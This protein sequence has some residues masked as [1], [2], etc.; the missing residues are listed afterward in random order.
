MPRQPSGRPTIFE[1]KDGLYHC[2][3]AIGT[4]TDGTP[5]RRHI[6]RKTAAAVA[7]AIEETLKRMRQ[8]SGNLAKIE[9][10]EQWLAHWVHVILVSKRDSGTMAWNSWEDYE[11][12]SRVHLV[13][14]LGR[15]RITGTKRRMEPEYPEALYAQLRQHDL[16]PSYVKRIH[17]V[18]CIAYKAAFKRGRADRNVMELV[19]A[20]EFR[21]KKIPALPQ[22]DAA[23]VLAEA[24]R[25]EHAA[26]WGLGIVAGPR[27]GEV[28]GIRWPRVDLDPE[29]PAVAHVMMATQIQRRKWRHG[30]ADPV[31][32]VASRDLC[33]TKRCE[34]PFGHGCAGAC[35][36]KLA[37]YC[38]SRVREGDCYRH[39]TKQGEPKPC[40]P[41]CPPN[42]AGHAST[43][44]QR[45]GGGLVETALKT[46][47]SEA[48]MVLGSV[49]TELLRRHREQQIQAGTFD[50][51]GFVFP[52][53]RKGAPLDPRQDYANWCNLLERAGVQ[54]YRLHSARHTAGTFASATGADLPMIRDMLR[55]ADTAVAA[56]Y[57]DNALD[58][59]RDAV[60]RVAAALFDG[61]LSMILGA[62]RVA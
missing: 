6:K 32:C 15:W 21:R 5:K 50:A 36:K 49:C 23:K 55:Q 62:K 46:H 13:P 14:N 39:I 42:C 17:R 47:A 26:R 27:Q 3:L 12:I 22:R 8:G 41:L 48:P 43:C 58:A 10:L 33:R 53:Y 24:I 38:P 44:P 29:P 30:C 11:S 18:L 25:D 54:H 7:E 16:A 45:T 28:L 9:T 4:T 61:D 52:G 20:P 2:Y 37:R 35:G 19:E 40:P 60:D 34:P 31:A 51:D 59:R 57:V 56:L 1:G